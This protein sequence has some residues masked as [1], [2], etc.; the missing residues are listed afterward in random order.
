VVGLDRE[1]L[2]AIKR[3]LP[4]ALALIIVLSVGAA[5]FGVV[6]AKVA[7]LSQLDGYLATSPGGVYA[8]LATAGG[9][10][11]NLTFVVAAQVIRIVLMLFAAPFVARAFMRFTP[12]SAAT[13]SASRELVGVAG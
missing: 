3:I 5:G 10:G 6:L 8:V 2:R 4:G 7:G 1:S 11:S 13:S 9:M 12:R